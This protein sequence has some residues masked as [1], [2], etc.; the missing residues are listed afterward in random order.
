MGNDTRRSANSGKALSLFRWSYDR[1]CM[2]VRCPECDG[3]GRYAYHHDPLYRDH[4]GGSAVY[5]D[6]WWWKPCWYCG[7]TGYIE[8]SDWGPGSEETLNESV[9]RL[10]L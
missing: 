1:D 5:H 4:V 7:G 6:G 9:E 8:P 10:R 3:L 2:T